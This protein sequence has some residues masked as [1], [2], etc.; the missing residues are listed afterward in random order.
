MESTT[1]THHGV[2]CSV[3]NWGD[4]LINLRCMRVL[5]GSRIF[6]D[7][8]AQDRQQCPLAIDVVW[9]LNWTGLRTEKMKEMAR[10]QAIG[11]VLCSVYFFVSSNDFSMK[12]MPIMLLVGAE[13]R[14]S[15][16]DAPFELLQRP[17][18]IDTSLV[19]PTTYTPLTLKYVARL[20]SRLD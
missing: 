17:Q 12:P 19:S 18:L 6:N 2:L 15:T 8:L 4:E 11:P 13:G 1:R 20:S 9:F 14:D 16:C 7:F 10:T 5:V 3:C